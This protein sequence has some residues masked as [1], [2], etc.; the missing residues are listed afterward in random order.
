MSGGAQPF[1]RAKQIYQAEGLIPL[2]RRGFA[3]LGYRLLDYRTYYLYAAPIEE[4]LRVLDQSHTVPNV[5][6]FSVKVVSSND[7]ADELEAQ[8]F[9]LRSQA[10]DV[11]ERLD[12]GAIA[13]CIFV[14]RELACIGW[15]ALTQEAMA[16]LDEPPYKVDFAN[17]ES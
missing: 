5:D 17:H 9:K 8:G 6:D 16:S 14:G 12:K 7:E 11:G 2:V 3:F 10:S 15:V 1:R 13:F 4:S